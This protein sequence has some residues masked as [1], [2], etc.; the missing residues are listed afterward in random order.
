VA[1]PS[2]VRKNDQEKKGGPEEMVII[3]SG[4]R[5]VNEGQ[6]EKTERI[7]AKNAESAALSGGS[8]GRGDQ[9]GKF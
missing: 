5:N 3:V 8:W 7:I 4:T 2:P 1:D 9:T 6:R